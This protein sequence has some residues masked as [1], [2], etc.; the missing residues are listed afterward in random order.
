MGVM[1]MQPRPMA[2][3]PSA[4]SFLRSIIAVLDSA[5]FATASTSCVPVKVIAGVSLGVGTLRS[6]RG[7]RGVMEGVL[8]IDFRDGAV[9]VSAGCRAAH[10]PVLSTPRGSMSNSV[11][12]TACAQRTT[13]GLFLGSFA[14]L[15]KSH[16]ICW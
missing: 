7:R 11:R 2:E 15:V 10:H 14:V 12:H 8:R 16:R 3:T 6:T 5:Y 1:L 4:P 9:H 13:N